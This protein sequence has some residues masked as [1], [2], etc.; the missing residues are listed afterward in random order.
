VSCALRVKRNFSYS[1]RAGRFEKRI[2]VHL[3]WIPKYRK[4]ALIGEVAVRTRDISS[5]R[6]PLAVLYDISSLVLKMLDWK[7]RVLNRL[8]DYKITK[9]GTYTTNTPEFCFAQRG[10]FCRVPVE[11]MHLLLESKF[12]KSTGHPLL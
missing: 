7:S 11:A 9:D 2:K 5:S 4:K 6:F 3:V 12:H 8:D 10:S 1:L